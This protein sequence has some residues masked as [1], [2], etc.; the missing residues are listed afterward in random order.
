MRCRPCIVPSACGLLLRAASV[1]VP[2]RERPDWL[3]EWRGELHYV[4][5]RGISHSECIAFSLGAVPDA[6]WIGRH[7][8]RTGFLPRR[9]SPRQCLAFLL[10]LAAASV[11]LAL[12]MPNVRQQIFPPAYDG[13][14]D[15]ATIS[16]VA[17]AVG[18]G[19]DVS[20]AQYKAWSAHPQ[21]DISEMAFY[22]PTLAKAR[23]GTRQETWHLGRTT[24]QFADLLDFHLPQSLLAA[25]RSKG[26]LPIV[27]SRDAWLRE[28]AG[29]PDIAGRVLLMEGRQAMIVAVAP[30]ITAD[31]PAQEDAWSLESEEAI[32]SLAF[33]EFAYGYLIARPSPALR[34]GRTRQFAPVQLADND[35]YYTHL[36]LVRLS[37]IARGHRSIPEIN[38]LLAL[39]I[40]CLM[41]P[42]V[43]AVALRTGMRTE[44]VSLKMRTRGWIFLGCK[45]ALLLPVLFCG[46]LVVSAALP[47]SHSVEPMQVFSTLGMCLFAGFW[48]VDDQRK[49]CPSCLRR[50]T[51]P[52]RVGERSR[53]FLDFSGIEYVC[54][55]GHGLLHVPDFPTSWFN[56]QRWLTLDPSWRSLFQHGII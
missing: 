35:L 3:A 28:F 53:S 39:L 31:L 29:D 15:L 44:W 25:C 27:L 32:R 46:P 36:Y 41:L 11:A 42:V 8:P 19:L 45:I 9:D 37:S 16:P 51:S 49:R 13:P 38:F 4:L 24:E 30:S 2:R 20:A 23:I 7:S 26:L 6:L 48:V 5:G 33:D 12:L 47:G 43:L 54:A 10:G 21:R 50:L 17:S 18:P 22:E 56:S 14:P 40:T 52:A 34:A 1:V 55:E